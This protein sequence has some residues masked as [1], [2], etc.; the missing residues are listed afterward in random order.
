MAV[1]TAATQIPWRDIIKYAPAA[2][3][4]LKESIDPIRSRLKASSKDSVDSRLAE[5]ESDLRD[6]LEAVETTSEQLAKR[7]QELGEA[8]QILTARIRV[9]III[10]LFSAFVALVA[11]IIALF[12]RA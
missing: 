8:G 7:I 12:Y 9:A 5:I 6:S 1:V 11:V 2:I 10:A 4:A 3:K